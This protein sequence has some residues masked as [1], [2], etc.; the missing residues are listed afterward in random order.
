MQ[1]PSRYNLKDLTDR[2]QQY[3]NNALSN[4]NSTFNSGQ[5]NNLKSWY[6]RARNHY[7]NQDEFD[8]L[9][10]S[11]LDEYLNQKYPQYYNGK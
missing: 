5:I 2:L 4:S 8:K 7:S 3:Q 11:T 9:Y 10:K 1:A 6:G